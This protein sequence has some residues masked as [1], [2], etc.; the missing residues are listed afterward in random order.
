MSFTWPIF[1]LY[2]ANL[3]FL[4]EKRQAHI[5]YL[6]GLHNCRRNW[7]MDILLEVTFGC[8]KK[9]RVR[10]KVK[11]NHFSEDTQNFLIMI[12]YW[13]SSHRITHHFS[14]TFAKVS[15]LSFHIIFFQILSLKER[16][17]RAKR[18]TLSDIE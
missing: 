18:D 14:V 7:R 8:K 15:R 4:C 1:F 2:L 13:L 17:L 11:K 3:H 10:K 9:K 6:F 16:K 12:T 5:L